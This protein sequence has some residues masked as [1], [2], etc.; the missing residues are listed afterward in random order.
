MRMPRIDL[1]ELPPPEI[2]EAIDYEA[3][4]QAMIDEMI[5]LHPS[6]AP[7]LRLQSEP[8]RKL[9]EVAA[10]R[11][12][13]LRQ[14]VND[15][16]RAVML[17]TAVG[18]D[19]DNLAANYGVRRL[20]VPAP[21]ES[22]GSPRPESDERLRR[23]V[24]LAIEAFSA[25]G[26]SGA[27]VYHALTAAPELRDATA[28]SAEP[29][30]VTVTLMQST[31]EPEP[32]EDQRVRVVAALSSDRVRPLT[33]IVI[34]SGPVVVETPIIAELLLYPG[35]D[36]A[37]V[38]ARAQARLEEW[39]ESVAYLGRDLRRSA[40]FSRL[41]VDGV[42]SVNLI[43]PAEDVIGNPRQAIMVPEISVTVAGG[44]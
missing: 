20:D 32:T 34:V 41:H 40:I 4:L 36:G 42:Q 5:A 25:A 1:S 8:V 35:P 33:D 30:S 11:E 37:V 3:I 17:A 21:A 19:L 24:L 29:G 23:R 7:V 43:S 38:T 15:A 26:P 27:Y 13:L 10:Y 28:I 14:R 16:A 39:L 31:D 44:A 9:L 6:I 22:S 2:V 12:I 18:A